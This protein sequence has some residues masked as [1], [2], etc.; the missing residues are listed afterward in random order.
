M[1]PYEN[2]P[3]AYSKLVV[4]GMNYAK[5]AGRIAMT[6]SNSTTQQGVFLLGIGVQRT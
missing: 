6:R 3:N 5:K 2:S 4:D 1:E